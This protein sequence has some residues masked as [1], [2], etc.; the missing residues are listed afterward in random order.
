MPYTVIRP[1]KDMRDKEQHEYKIDDV[2]PRKGYEPDQ[3]FVKGL[4]TGFNSAGSIFITDEVVKK[5]TKKAEEADEEVETTTEEVEETSEEVETTT[6]EVEETSEEVETTTEEVE[7]A[8]EEKPK[9]KKATKKE[10][11]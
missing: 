7:E 4:L 2:F 10:E 3:E 5:A 9:R 8:T 1:F 6:E 11:E